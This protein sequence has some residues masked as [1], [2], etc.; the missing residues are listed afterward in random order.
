MITS[1]CL[2]W[3]NTLHVSILVLSSFTITIISHLLQT[4]VV[5]TSCNILLLIMVITTPYITMYPLPCTHYHGNHY[6]DQLLA[7]N[8]WFPRLYCKYQMYEQDTI[9]ISHN[10]SL[11]P[12]QAF[13]TSKYNLNN[14]IFVIAYLIS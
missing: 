5:S 1:C 3:E 4:I 14:A 6:T 8:Y 12:D 10:T 2:L 7:A 13:Y 11:T 9:F